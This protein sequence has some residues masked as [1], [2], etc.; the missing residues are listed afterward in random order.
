M[1][2]KSKYENYV[3]CREE[4]FETSSNFEYLWEWE[5]EYLACWGLVICLDVMIIIFAIKLVKGVH[6]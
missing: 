3:Y 2:V 5:F 6:I 4:N 1:K